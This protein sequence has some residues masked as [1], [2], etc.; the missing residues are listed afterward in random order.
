MIDFCRIS[1]FWK[2][3]G[4]DIQNEPYLQTCVSFWTLLQWCNIRKQNT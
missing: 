1:S 3:D 2:V 4:R